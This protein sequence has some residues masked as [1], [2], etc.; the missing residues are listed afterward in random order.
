LL[1]R[2]REVRGEVHALA[3]ARDEILQ[4][5]RQIGTRPA[6]R[7][8]ILASSMSMHQTSLPTSAKPAAV[9]RPT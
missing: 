9:T 5:G 1:Q 3:V 4:A 8:A 6:S 2:V 7:P